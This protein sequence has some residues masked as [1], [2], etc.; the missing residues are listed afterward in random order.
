MWKKPATE[1][2][3]KV[4]ISRASKLF[5]PLNMARPRAWIVVALTLCIVGLADAIS[6]YAIWF[7]PL[8]LMIIGF[9]AWSLGWREAVGVGLSCLGITLVVNGF[10]IYPYGTAHAYWNLAIRILAVLVIIGILDSARKLCENEWLLARTDPLTGVLNRQAFFELAESIDHSET[11]YVLVY[12]DLDG[13]K[14]LNDRE[15]HARGDACLQAYTAHV[16]QL[17]RKDDIFARVGGDEFFI[18]L[19]VRDEEAGKAV[20]LRLHKGMNEAAS[21]FS[22]SLRCST[23]ALILAP[24][25]RSLSREVKIADELMYQA[26]NAGA[27]LR[28]ASVHERRG[29]LYVSPDWKLSA[30]FGEEAGPTT[31]ASIEMREQSVGAA[32]EPIEAY[33]PSTGIAAA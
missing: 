31:C 28:V 11:W 20:A 22:A 25:S 29:S 18:Y 14:R 1:R 27:S 10:S 5:F 24:G 2:R 4:N 21:E 23:G 16:Q 30:A 8:Y 13:L 17:I 9:A 19:A 33:R 12:A 7:G 3:A 32:I 26:K 6:G 15:G